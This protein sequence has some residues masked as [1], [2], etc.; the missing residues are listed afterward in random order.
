[1]LI[2][3]A[4]RSRRALS[5]ALFLWLAAVLV[6]GCGSIRKDAPGAGDDDGADTGDGA[7]TD[8]AGDGEDDG[9]TDGGEPGPAELCTGA[10]GERLRQ[11]V[12]VHGDGTS[13]SL[14]LR[15][16]VLG[17]DCR[18]ARDHEGTMR[19]LPSGPGPFGTQGYRI[20][21]DPGCT[22]LLAAFSDLTSTP[23]VVAFSEERDCQTIHRYHELGA[24][25]SYP[26]ESTAYVVNP[27][28]GLCS[29]ISV[30]SPRDRYF[31]AAAEIGPERFMALTESV[32][33]EGRLG[34]RVLEGDD[35]SRFCDRGVLFDAELGAGPCSA[36]EG[37]DGVMRCLP[38][39]ND[40]V[41]VS[42]SSQCT[43]SVEVTRA[44]ATCGLDRTYSRER[45]APG[46]S[47][48]WQVRERGGQLDGT[49]HLDFEIACP[50]A[51]VGDT[52]HEIGPVAPPSD[53]PEL[54][55]EVVDG[56]NRLHR[57]DH[58]ADGVRIDR[59]IWYDSELGARCAFP[60]A[61]TVSSRCLPGSGQTREAGIGSYF[62]DPSCA[63]PRIEVAVF[64]DPC[65]FGGEPRYAR[66]DGS[67]IYSIRDRLT[68]PRFHI[69][70]GFC[71]QTP[72]TLT[73]YSLGSQLEEE[74]FVG[75][76][77]EIE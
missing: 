54:R 32:S 66:G 44:R 70:D 65:G 21:S 30:G 20:Y 37:T 41:R 62:T 31:R 69:S 14:G 13:E 2:F 48:R 47:A 3:T 25:V 73:F 33:S 36:A 75:G 40:L 19:C 63:G 18:F 46:C 53:F 60:P 17:F 28:S 4:G 29:A 38:T 77:L 16:T 72:E 74:M 68:E 52:Y 5:P 59:G 9:S 1:M 15:D 61:P 39:S 58:V 12:R 8:G 35:G 49:F 57:I 22:D 26:E 11:I 64:H 42:T 51:P 43:G 67:L 76:I 45:V 7:D 34:V 27:E 10:S 23:L 71:Q 50:L 56:G 24:E 55:E 6:T